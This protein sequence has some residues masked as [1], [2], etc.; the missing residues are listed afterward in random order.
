MTVVSFGLVRRAMSLNAYIHIYKD[1]ELDEMRV[2]KG[3]TPLVITDIEISNGI[4][5]N[6]VH[7]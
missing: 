2:N 3:L 1:L 4:K 5:F 7:S 6:Y